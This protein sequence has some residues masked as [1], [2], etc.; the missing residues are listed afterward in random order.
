MLLCARGRFRG[1]LPLHLSKKRIDLIANPLGLCSGI[2]HERVSGSSC[3]ATFLWA[4]E[5]L[6]YFANFFREMLQLVDQSAADLLPFL[7]R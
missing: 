4:R 3:L 6:E 2:R 5:P 7:W 1:T